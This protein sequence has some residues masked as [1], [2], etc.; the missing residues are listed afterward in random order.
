MS[1]KVQTHSGLLTGAAQTMSAWSK[2]IERRE[3]IP[4][5]YRPLF[6][7]TF[8]E[9]QPFPRVVLTPALDRSPRRAGEK[10]VVDAADALH[11][12]ERDRSGVRAKCYAYSDV[13]SLEMG[14]VLLYSWLTVHGCTRQGE[15]AASTIELNTTS[16]PHLR[17]VLR[18]LRPGASNADPAQFAAEKDKF[19]ALANVNFK[20]MNYGRES[21]AAGET[22]LR[23]VLQPEIR[24]PLITL[25]GRTFSRTI[26]PVHLTIL[27]DR[28]LIL[29]RNPESIKDTQVDRY[30]GIWQYIPLSYL[31]SVQLSRAANDRLTL[32]IGHRPGQ[33]TERLFDASHQREVEQLCSQVQGMRP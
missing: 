8:D 17:P 24:Q 20:F 14:I 3:Q 19:D 22:V 12:F 33:T 31:E 9:S 6:D 5:A 27:S 4:S 28:E 15:I 11:L 23:F 21:L 7:Q 10:L 26:S 25:F 1:H 18:K 32:S 13:Y 30:G 16:L 2:V 29:I